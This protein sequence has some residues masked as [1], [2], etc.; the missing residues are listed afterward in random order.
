MAGFHRGLGAKQLSNI[1]HANALENPHKVAL[2][3][4]D[5][6]IAYQ[7]LDESTTSLAHWFLDHG[8]RPG[9][10]VAL[11]WSNSIELVQL[12][13]ALFKA[14][15]I[16]VTVNL[17]L[18]A[19]EIAYILEHSQARLCFSEPAL[20]PLARQAGSSC[21]IRSELPRLGAARAEAGLPAAVDLDD[22]AIVLYTSGTTARP[23]G[24]T[25]SHR[26][27][28]HTVRIMAREMSG[29][30]EVALTTTQMMHAAALNMVVLPA[31][32]LGASAVLLASLDADIILDA[33]ER[34]RCSY[35][36]FLPTLQSV[37][38]RQ[39]QQSRQ[40][41]S[42]RR[43]LVGGDT[44][45]AALQ[46]RFEKF[47][48]TKL[49]E[50]YGMTE[51]V[52]MTLNPKTAIRTGST[53]LGVEGF[54]LRIVDL[55]GR[56]VAEDETGEILVRGPAV[57]IGY[58]N[59]LET[60]QTAMADGWLRT[61]DLARRDAGGYYWFQGRKKEIII[62]AGSNISPQEVE[63]A[64]C[65]HPAVLEA[66][67][68]GMTDP[69]YGEI[70]AACLV[71]RENCSVDARQLRES[72]AQYLADYKLPERIVFLEE[73]PK[74]TTGKVQRR[75]LKEMLSANPEVLASRADAKP[76][77]SFVQS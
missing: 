3:C 12:L 70:V 18:K 67:V 64:L 65:R 57:C 34:F 66:G 71:L 25:H 9:D 40:V 1:L 17:R 44:I 20:A 13:F 56:D 38:E 68:I 27:L 46:E 5:E 60:T 41:S 28:F 16:V 49:R 55:S 58:W 26:S 35:A 21:P 47:F 75:A 24:V 69:V 52:P 4:G 19:P 45:S 14:G 23:K 54:E 39:A 42:L 6:A 8:L 59:D 62:R 61:G 77:P 30:D 73:L 7:A 31:L 36:V 32:S 15:L 53:G 2:L 63:A 76:E 48:G 50:A 72:A 29:P 37:I 43:A 74:G 22:P 51:A 10:R 11:H 33:I